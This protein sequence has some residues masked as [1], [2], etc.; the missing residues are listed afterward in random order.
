MHSR[1]VLFLLLSL[2]GCDSLG[3]D[4]VALDD[5]LVV[6]LVAAG[7]TA[8]PALAFVTEG[9]PGCATPIVYQTRV[10]RDVLTVEVDGLQVETGPTCRALIPSGFT[11]A[12]PSTRY[13]GPL[14]VEI[15]HRGETDRYRVQFGAGG[16]VLVP[17]HTSQT[18]LGPR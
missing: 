1:V 11:V 18:R 3:G 9:V 4:V 6:D 10:A 12:L 13:G 14:A 7:G 8:P 16:L 15:R 17:I 2:A 5:V